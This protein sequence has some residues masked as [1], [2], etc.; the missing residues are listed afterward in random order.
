MHVLTE[1]ANS[2]AICMA[3]IGIGAALNAVMSVLR[4]WIEQTFRTRRLT[5]ALEDSKPHQRPEIIRAFSL[6][7]VTQKG[8]STDDKNS[9]NISGHKYPSSPVAIIE[10]ELN[11]AYREVDG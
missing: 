8:K 5:R 7:E 1:A 2:T 10:D 9:N 3:V 11:R 4:T 6:L